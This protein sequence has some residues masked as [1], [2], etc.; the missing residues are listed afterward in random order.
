[1]FTCFSALLEQILCEKGYSNVS[2]S[3]FLPIVHIICDTIAI[4]FPDK[5]LSKMKAVE[6][7]ALS[8]ILFAGLSNID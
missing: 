5:R 3:P 8:H 4:L 2:L 7:A 6:Y 1:M